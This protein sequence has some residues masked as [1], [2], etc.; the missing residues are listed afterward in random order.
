MLIGKISTRMVTVADLK[1]KNET[2]KV[3]I[4]RQLARSIQENTEKRMNTIDD[5]KNWDDMSVKEI[6]Q[7]ISR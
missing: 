4:M 7:E 2:E 5:G 3:I 6:Y 1:K